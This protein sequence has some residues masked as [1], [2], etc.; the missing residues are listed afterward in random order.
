MTVSGNLKLFRSQQRVQE[1]NAEREGN[2][3][4][5]QVIHD[6]FLSEPV[7]GLDEHPGDCEEGD[8]QETVS[9]VKHWEPQFQ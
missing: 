3:S 7:T 4:G 8:D 9:N 2:H 1:I 5:N 6:S